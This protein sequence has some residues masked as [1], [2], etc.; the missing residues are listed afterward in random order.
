[1]QKMVLVFLKVRKKKNTWMNI[2]KI[3]KENNNK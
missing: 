1:M 2:N 3:D